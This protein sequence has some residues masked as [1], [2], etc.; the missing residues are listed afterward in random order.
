MHTSSTAKVPRTPRLLII[1]RQ[2]Y[3][4]CTSNIFPPHPGLV[5]FSTVFATDQAVGFS[6]P[7]PLAL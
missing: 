4:V 2:F 6:L 7:R 5:K 1:K 3:F